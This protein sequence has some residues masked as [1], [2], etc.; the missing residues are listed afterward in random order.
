MKKQAV[1]FDMDGVI[2]DSEPFYAE[3][4]NVVLAERGLALTEENHRAIMGSS[5]DY[6]WQWVMDHF[7]LPGK[8]SQWKAPYDRAVVD[9]L[10]RKVER[11]P[12][13]MELL[14]AITQR[15]LKIGLA[16]SSQLNWAETVLARLK[17]RD[18]FLTIATAEMV[19]EAKPAPDLYLFAA[20]QLGVA[21]AACIAIEDSPRGIGSAKNAGITTVAVRTPSTEGMDISAADYIIDSLG[22]FDLRWL[23]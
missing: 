19:A 5:I 4:V 18:R 6:T 1:I 2:T 13:L 12:G 20:R 7:H 9:I 17:V 16:T 15:K 21:P 22:E 10:S 8:I 3:A 11:A 14:D 23:G